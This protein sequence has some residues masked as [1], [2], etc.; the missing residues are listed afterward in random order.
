[1]IIAGISKDVSPGFDVIRSHSSY[2]GEL[3]CIEIS[4]SIYHDFLHLHF[5]SILFVFTNSYFK[6]YT[7]CTIYRAQHF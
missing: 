4:Y 1:M 7:F 5:S 3:A 6:V 2:S